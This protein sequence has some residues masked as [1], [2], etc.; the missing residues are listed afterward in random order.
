MSFWRKLFPKCRK[1]RDTLVQETMTYIGVC[2]CKA[3]R[4]ALQTNL[5]HRVRELHKF[6]AKERLGR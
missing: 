5:K 4:E 3:A 1:C 2:D 6:F